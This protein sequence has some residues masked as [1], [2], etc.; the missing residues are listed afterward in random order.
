MAGS[1]WYFDIEI[2][3]DKFVEKDEVFEVTVYD[4]NNDWKV[5]INTTIV[6]I[7]DDDSK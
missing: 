4:P 3:D 6:L 1:R 7:K 2:F 5:H